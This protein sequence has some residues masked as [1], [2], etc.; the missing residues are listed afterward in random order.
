MFKAPQ[1]PSGP[2]HKITIQDLSSALGAPSPRPRGEGNINKGSYLEDILFTQ[3]RHI[4]LITLQR[5]QALN[6]LTLP[7]ILDLQHQLQ[8]WQED[9]GIH[10]VVIRAAA[11]KAFCAGGDVRGLYELGMHG[12]HEQMQ[13]FWHEYRLNHFIHHFSKPYIALMDGVTMGGGVG[14]SMHGSHPV[15]TEHFMFAMPETG[16]GFFP[17]IGASYLLSQCSGSLGI[18]LGLT[19]NR[20]NAAEALAV[21]LVKQQMGSEN[22]QNMLDRLI[23][24]DLSTD[25]YKRVNACLKPFAIEGMPSPIMA[26][27][28]AIDHCFS[29]SDVESIMAELEKGDDAWH[30]ETL[31][32]LAKK[33]PLSLKVTLAQLHKAKK[34]SMAECIKMDYRLVVHFMRDH[35]FYEG[36]RAL[37]VDKDKSPHWQPRSLSDVTSTML[38]DYFECGN[39]ALPLGF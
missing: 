20:L 6:A 29:G 8:T 39:S 10:A 1:P 27:Q 18:Y 2:Q 4:G 25:A 7:M 15:A 9:V 34:M 11:G 26:L 36:V 32:L 33:S 31:Q 22:L 17:D 16:I 37:L 3:E 21:G 23:D 19:G 28:G 35:D 30:S 14:I 38:S 12:H 24:A 5:V 13:F